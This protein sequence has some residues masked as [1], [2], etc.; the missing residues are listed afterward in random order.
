M[1][2]LEVRRCICIVLGSL[3]ESER[4]VGSIILVGMWG[5]GVVPSG[6][7]MSGIGSMIGLG[8]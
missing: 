8:V 1:R 4:G 3:A 6:P 5:V 2:D 7:S